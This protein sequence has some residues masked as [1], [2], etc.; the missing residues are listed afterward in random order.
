MAAHA[1]QDDDRPVV[2]NRTDAERAQ[3]VRRYRLFTYQPD[4]MIT[5]MSLGR[6]HP[7]RGDLDPRLYQYGGL[8]IYPVGAMLK[9]ASLAGWVDLRGGPEGIAYYLDHPG[10]FG[11]FYVVARAYVALWGLVGVWAV[12]EIVRRVVGGVLYPAVAAGCFVAMPVVVN[13][14]HEAKPHLP[15]AVLVLLAVLAAAR[16]AE[17]G[18]RRACLG[19]GPCAG[20]RRGWCSRPLPPS[21]CC[22]P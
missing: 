22:R 19:A 16:F 7:G 17:T 18:S 2:V 9:A 8:W 3:I 4:E 1:S 14:A 13:M 15:G 10:A 20:R 6:M 21:P 12:F 11:R 5:L